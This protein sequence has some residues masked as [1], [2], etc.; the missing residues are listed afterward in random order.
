MEMQHSNILHRCFRCGYCKMPSDFTDLNCP[1]YLKYR[2]ETFSP[3]GR[4][5]L[6][7]GLAGRRDSGQPRFQEI[8]YSLRHLRQLRRTLRN[9]QVQGPP[10]GRI[11]RGPLPAGRRGRRA[12]GRA[13]LFK[14]MHV[15]GNPTSCPRKQGRLGQGSGPAQV[16]WPG[17]PFVYRRR[18]LLRRRG[19]KMAAAV[20]KP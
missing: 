20:A 18:G 14:A 9:A 12:A 13:R 2:F 6:L 8:I 5:W 3:G 19:P 7:R 17:I 10:P 4:M 11:H 1:S 16:Q 15:N